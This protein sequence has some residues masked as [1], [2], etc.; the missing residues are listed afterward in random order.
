MLNIESPKVD[1]FSWND[2]ET[3]LPIVNQT[4]LLLDKIGSDRRLKQVFDIEKTAG[5]KELV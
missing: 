3:L 5:K 4:A 1:A 2:V